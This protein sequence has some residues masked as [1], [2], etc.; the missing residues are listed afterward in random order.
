M[1]VIA[2]EHFSASHHPSPLM[3]LDHVSRQAV[4]HSFF[5]MTAN[6]IP[7]PHLN[8]VKINW[9]CYKTEQCFFLTLLLYG[10]ILMIVMINVSV[11][12]RYIYY[13]CWHIHKHY[14]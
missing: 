5:L 8:T 6:R 10:R 11:Q 1:E 7:Q 14:D 9:N 13:Q 4:F 3:T 2:L 12:L